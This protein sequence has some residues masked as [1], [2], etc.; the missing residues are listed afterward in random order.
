MT[1]TKIMTAKVIFPG[2][3]EQAVAM[4]NCVKVNWTRLIPK[5]KQQ[6]WE[7]AWE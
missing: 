2:V 7:F 3:G 4:K 6:C 5:L 1:Q